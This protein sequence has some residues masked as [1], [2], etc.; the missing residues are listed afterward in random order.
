M[1]MIQILSTTYD[2]WQQA[3]VHFHRVCQDLWNSMLQ[4]EVSLIWFLKIY[5]YFVKGSKMFFIH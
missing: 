4:P 1:L 3:G 5:T 2:N